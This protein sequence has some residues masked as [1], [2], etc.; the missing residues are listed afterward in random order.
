[1]VTSLG[2]S[3]PGSLAA[4]RGIIANYTEHESVLVNED[5]YGTELS[6]VRIARLPEQTWRTRTMI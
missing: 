5:A 1:M 2:Y 4:I 6:S 3:A